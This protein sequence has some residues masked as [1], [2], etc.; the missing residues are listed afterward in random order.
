MKRSDTPCYFRGAAIAALFTTLITC[1]HA[2]EPVMYDPVT[3]IITEAFN[4]TGAIQIDGTSLPGHKENVATTN[5]LATS[6]SASGYSVGSR[7]LNTAT[8]VI[9]DCFDASVGAA[10][11][12]S[13]SGGG[14]GGSGSGT[15]TTI[16][17][18]DVAVGGADIVTLDFSSEFG[19]AETP[20]TE[21]QISI[22]AAITRDTEWDT[23]AELNAILSLD[24]DIAT[25]SVPAS[26]TI[27]AFGATVI[28]DADASAA[29]TTLG[30]DPIGTDNST[31]VT[32]AGTPDY[33]T[34]VGQTITVGLIDMATDTSGTILDSSLSGAITRDIE[35]DTEAEIESLVGDVNDFFTNNDGALDDD[36]VSATDLGAASP[37]LD[38]TDAS[39]EWE[40]AADLDTTGNILAGAVGSAETGHV[41]FQVVFGSSGG[42]LAAA[43]DQGSFIIPGWMTG[44]WN[45]T[46]VHISV[47]TAGA[48]GSNKPSYQIHNVSDA[49]NMLTTVVTLDLSE[50]GSDTAAVAYAIDAAN[51]DVTAY[52]RIRIDCT[53]M[54]DTV[55]QGFGVATMEF[56][57]Q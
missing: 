9:W 42:A 51:D 24:V 20:D 50:T 29:R 53:L 47:G 5:P 57:K 17:S 40:D 21:I 44:T 15:L 14:G 52:K 35:I 43:N 2:R 28:D 13:G 19:A 1:V 31:A 49:A 25:L 23:F 18:N 39:V 11:W 6:D 8:G 12:N 56:E 45:L 16:K 3:L 37:S 27:S 46:T 41:T 10:D 26:T 30:V 54:S 38:P 48:A 36:D 32:L 4:F 55:A 34:L 22:D 33:L 7:W